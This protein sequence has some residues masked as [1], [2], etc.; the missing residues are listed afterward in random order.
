MSK[1]DK[2]LTRLEK[3]TEDIRKESRTVT[4][5]TI[6]TK[7]SEKWKSRWSLTSFTNI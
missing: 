5:D 3:K 6:G 1:I 2:P 7:R 4:P